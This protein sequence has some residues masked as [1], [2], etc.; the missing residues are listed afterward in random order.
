MIFRNMSIVLTS[1]KLLMDN[2][3]IFPAVSLVVALD[4]HIIKITARL[5]FFGSRCQ[6]IMYE[7]S[8]TFIVC[9]KISIDDYHKKRLKLF[10]VICRC[11]ADL[12]IV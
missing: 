10:D 1:P 9:H 11:S 4:I 7:L 3:I 2:S 5:F 8:R 12:H 6:S